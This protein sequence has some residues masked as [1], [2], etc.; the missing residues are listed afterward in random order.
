M[1]KF[2]HFLPCIVMLGFSV[3][4]KSRDFNK[5][6]ERAEL[7]MVLTSTPE[8]DEALMGMESLQTLSPN[9]A[10]DEK[11]ANEVCEDTSPGSGMDGVGDGTGRELCLEARKNSLLSDPA[12][13]TRWSHLA[14]VPL[15]MSCSSFKKLGASNYGRKAYKQVYRVFLR[16]LIVSPTPI[17]KSSAPSDC[18]SPEV[19]RDVDFLLHANSL[20]PLAVFED[21]SKLSGAERI[22]RLD[23][24]FELRGDKAGLRTGDVFQAIPMTQ[25]EATFLRNEWSDGTMSVRFISKPFMSF[26]VTPP[27]MVSGQFAFHTPRAQLCQKLNEFQESANELDAK[28]EDESAY[29]E[30]VAA[31]TRRCIAI[32]PFGDG[33]GRACGL[34]SVQALARG[35]QLPSVRWPHADYSVS[36]PNYTAAFLRGIANSKKM[37][38]SMR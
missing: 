27:A 28:R 16:S 9:P 36:L 2:Q 25:T 38:S 1:I 34:W 15:T 30:G 5:T 24:K 32:H 19:Q 6:E 29:A 20:L 21:L 12:Q 4:C 23:S 33:N 35:K 13:F 10:D 8:C 18:A 31:L 7:N 17:P 37:I 14:S 11:A 3:S 22:S 26:D